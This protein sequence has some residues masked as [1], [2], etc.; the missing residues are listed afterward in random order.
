MP[1]GT[2][3]TFSLMR[4]VALAAGVAC[5]LAFAVARPHTPRPRG[6]RSML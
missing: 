1:D 2:R 3:G 5:L 4:V 6:R